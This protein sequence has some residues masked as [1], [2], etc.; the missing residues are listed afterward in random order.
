MV[1]G[2]RSLLLP[3]HVYIPHLLWLHY[4]HRADVSHKL[5]F[6]QTTNTLF[7]IV[8]NLEQILIEKGKK[9]PTLPSFCRICP[10]ICKQTDWTRILSLSLAY[11]QVPEKEMKIWIEKWIML[12]PFSAYEGNLNP[13]KLSGISQLNPS[14]LNQILQP[15][16]WQ[17][18]SARRSISRQL[19]EHA[20]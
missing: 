13:S 6:W 14:G 2:S 12:L 17:R 16:R 15:E 1:H 18:D 7:W 20:A 11:C 19:Y 5:K 9:K 10:L 3:T 4:R 8:K